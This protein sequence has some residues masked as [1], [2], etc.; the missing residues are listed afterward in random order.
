[1]TP[2]SGR[3]AKYLPSDRSFLPEHK[4]PRL[5]KLI[6]KKDEQILDDI[7]EAI[8]KQPI[9]QLDNTEDNDILDDL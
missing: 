1:M 3:S 8:K 4:D 2:I 7:N 6:E 9:R 5:D